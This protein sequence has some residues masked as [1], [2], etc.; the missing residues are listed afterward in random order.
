MTRD[1]GVILVNVLVVLAIGAAFVVLMFTSQQPMLERA[2]IAAASSQAMA[3]ARGA[4]TSVRIAL[5]RDMR[6]APERDHLK[7]PWAAVAQEVVN[8]VTGQFSVDI[9]DAQAKFDLNILANPNVIQ[10]QIFL[11]LIRAVKLP[12]QTARDILAHIRREG[13]IAQL[14]D[15]TAL[16][17]ADLLALAPYFTALPIASGGVNMNTADGIVLGAVLNNPA[18]ARQ[19]IKRRDQAGFITQGDLTDLGIITTN[20]A[21]FTSQIFDTV[22]TAEVDSTR[23]I[24]RSRLLRLRGVGTQE[25]RV[26][27]RRVGQDGTP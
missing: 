16:G 3:L 9:Y 24:L 14:A 18:A 11:R 2:R 17:D 4:E 10:E 19:L 27:S 23:I 15:I 7:E 6:T 21:G 25:V 22:I 1:A 5:R 20:G 26:I 12:E 8:L 13:A